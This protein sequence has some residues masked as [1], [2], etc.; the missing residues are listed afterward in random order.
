MMIVSVL[1]S[2]LS[3]MHRP[4]IIYIVEKYAIVANELPKLRTSVSCVAS[5]VLLCV[6]AYFKAEDQPLKP[7]EYVH[8]I[9]V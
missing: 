2:V 4:C 9:K 6:R 7:E 8:I 5:C 1:S 3:H